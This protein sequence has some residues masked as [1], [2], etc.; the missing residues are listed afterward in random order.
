M[1]DSSISGKT[2]TQGCLKSRMR[3]KGWDEEPKALKPWLP[4]SEKRR[5][6]VLSHQNGW[7]TAQ[8]DFLM[9]KRLAV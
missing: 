6:N 3:R 5:P 2:L 4:E 8:R 1:G 7:R 9:K